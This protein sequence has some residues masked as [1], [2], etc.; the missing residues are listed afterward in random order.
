MQKREI[1]WATNNVT[2]VLFPVP[3]ETFEIQHYLWTRADKPVPT[4]VPEVKEAPK[5]PGIGYSTVAE[6]PDVH[7]TASDK[8]FKTEVAAKSAM[9]KK[10]LSEDEWMPTEVDDGFII[11]RK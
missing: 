6:E 3:K 11:T 10:S 8:P 1:V 9:K 7:M 5:T 4:P 2:G